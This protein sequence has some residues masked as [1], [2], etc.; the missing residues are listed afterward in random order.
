MKK[1]F[2]LAAIFAA[3]MMSFTACEETKPDNGGT[4]TDENLCPDCGKD[5]CECEPEYVSPITVDGDFSDW[6]ALD[7]SKVAVATCAAEAKDPAL[8]VL[9]VYADEVYVNLYFEY[10]ETALTNGTAAFDIYLN[11]D[12]DLGGADDEHWLSQANV[13]YL[14][15]DESIIVNGTWESFDPGMF[16]YTGTTEEWAWSWEE[17]LGAGSGIASGAGNGNK[18]ELAIMIEMLMG[19]ELADTFSLGCILTDIDATGAW[20]GVG[21]IPNTDVTDENTTG[22]VNFLEVTMDK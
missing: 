14:L 12:N 5:P 19:V 7:A 22:S 8:K 3:A 4:T 2:T 9:K 10:D 21:C 18:Y 15:E 6:D 13:D 16:H 1:I 17:V 20:N 11:Q